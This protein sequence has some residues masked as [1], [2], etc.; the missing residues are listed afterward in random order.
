MDN[1]RLDPYFNTMAFILAM[2]CPCGNSFQVYFPKRTM[3]VLSGKGDP[4][5][6]A[7]ADTHEETNGEIESAKYVSQICG[8]QFV[9]MRQGQDFRCERCRVTYDGFEAFKV[10]K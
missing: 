2:R 7:W 5:V 9:D 6:A 8:G 1:Q 3:F 4:E 10:G